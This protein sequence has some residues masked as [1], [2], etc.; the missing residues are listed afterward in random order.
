[1]RRR[2]VK[3]KLFVVVVCGVLAGW[4][5]AASALP[6]T[7]V[8]GLA[9]KFVLDAYA[10]MPSQ[11][12]IPPPAQATRLYA[13][14]GKTLITRFYE[15]DRQVVPLAQISPLM[16]KAMVA[17]EDRRF[18]QHGGVD[19]RGVVRA[20]V[21][22][23]KG[24]QNEQGASTLTMQY[25]RNV[26]K[27]DADLT[28]QQRIDATSNTIKR[29]LQ[30]MRYAQALEKRM[31]KQEI[32]GRYLNIAYFGSGAYGIES[33]SQRYFGRPARALTL[34]QA[35]LI[36]GLVQSPDTDSPI[37]GDRD[38][39]LQRRAYVLDAMV[40]MKAISQQQA[41][42]AKA[43]PLTLKTSEQ[44][45]SCAAVAKK[46]NDWGFYCDYFVQWWNSQQAFG[47]TV[48]ERE[49]ALKRGGYTIVT[50][51]DPGTQAAALEQ[52]LGVYGYSNARTLPMAVV[53]P[54]TGRVLAMAVNRHYGLA[55]GASNTVNQ[56]IAGGGGVNGYQAGSTFKMFTMLAAL[57]A[58]KPLNTGFNAPSPL[59]TKWPGSGP[60][61]CGGHYCPSNDNPS[62]MDGFR[63]MWNGF[64]RSVNT[65]FVW[66]EEQIGP[67]KAV[68]M[69]QRLGITFR[70]DSDAELAKDGADGW[71]S[72][73]LG[74]A[75]TTP[76]DI[77][78]AYATVAAE[79]LYCRPLPVKSIV[80]SGGQ[81]LSAA[82]PT[83]RQVIS[84]DIAR[85]ATDA[86]RCP[87][88]QQ[89]IAP[90]PAFAS[91]PTDGKCDGGTA[92]AVSGI[93]DGRPVAG[94]TG[95]SENNATETFVGFTPQLA[96]AAIAANPDNPQDHV[97][98]AVS[99]RVNAA[100]AKTMAA[101]LEGVPYEDFQPPSRQL[102]FG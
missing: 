47:S 62:W 69:A 84:S 101:A 2:S 85:A 96:A 3:A 43:E 63:T 72:F 34:S 5:L 60:G 1:M 80:D 14:D 19:L 58:G 7:A 65:Y 18:Y 40:R 88:G 83:C 77:A 74:V 22:N 93:L 53:Q 4:V 30:E 16:Q 35:A 42:L 78:N 82:D 55:K 86:A 41:D 33:A 27:E 102:A 36:A 76:L 71:G 12:K 75:D 64:G 97:G 21:S 26:Q 9:T 99:P 38:A 66:L 32:L 15:E 92:T 90:P 79:G 44:P 45:N 20:F 11:L 98:S 6:A 24:D 95:S 81:A 17:A 52:S 91:R 94:K 100:V 51:L 67:Q 89:S 57:E 13:N 37:G 61:S 31:S 48:S 73:T 10:R 28:P 49:S 39:A 70:A 25:V 50:A 23:A 46:H 56:L 59:V 68:E 87:V 54:G 29:K 8:A